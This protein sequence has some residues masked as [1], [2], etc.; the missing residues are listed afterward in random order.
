MVEPI[1][2]Q[3][4]LIIFGISATLQPFLRTVTKWFPVDHGFLPQVHLETVLSRVRYTTTMRPHRP[5]RVRP[6][7]YRPNYNANARPTSVDLLGG[8]W[9]NHWQRGVSQPPV[10]T[11]VASLPAEARETNIINDSFDLSPSLGFSVPVLSNNETHVVV[12]PEPSVPV[13]S[14]NETH[15]VATPEF[16]IPVSFNNETHIVARPEPT[17]LVETSNSTS[18]LDRRDKP[19]H[20]YFDA[21][22]WHG[23]HRAVWF[24][25]PWS[26][27]SL[28]YDCYTRGRS[29]ASR[30]ADDYTM[31][32]TYSKDSPKRCGPMPPAVDGNFPRAITN[33]TADGEIPA[34]KSQPEAN[35]TGPNNAL[36]RRDDADDVD[37]FGNP[38][39]PLLEKYRISRRVQFTNPWFRDLQMCGIAYWY[40]EYTPEHWLDIRFVSNDMLPCIKVIDTVNIDLSTE[41]RWS[42]DKS[43]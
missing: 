16:S 10:I 30:N 34:T 18:A 5:H 1:F 36:D 39:W 23:Y 35:I 13:S 11:S 2:L 28:C 21:D 27:S 4:I 32:C 25:H 22:K 43:P 29:K 41:Q 37:N 15:I 7:Q 38:L 19:Q 12:T 40:K 3:P 14:K 24:L 9:N 6:G 17:A 26:L 8:I 33:M 31:G 20:A 42:G